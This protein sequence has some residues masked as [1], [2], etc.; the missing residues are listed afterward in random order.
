MASFLNSREG[1]TQGDKIYMVPYDI[2]I[3]LLI[4]LPKAG[5]PDVTHPWYADNSSALGTFA[6]VELYILI[7]YNDSSWVV[8]IP[9]KPLKVF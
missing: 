6:N 9:P 8:D 5:F 1:V 7:C 4:K 3:I 2:G